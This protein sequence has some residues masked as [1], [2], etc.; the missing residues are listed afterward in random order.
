MTMTVTDQMQQLLAG[1]KR[2]TPQAIAGALPA[3]T[4]HEDGAELARFLLRID[5]RFEEENGEFHCLTESI[6]DDGK[7]LEAADRY[8]DDHGKRGELLE[9]LAVYIESETGA[10][11]QEIAEA[12]SKYYVTATGGQMI[13]RRRRNRSG[14]MHT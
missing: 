12:V 6:P 13:L 7:I 3:L 14:E 10:T 11:R 2:L 5:R 8:F 9:H 4:E 1:G